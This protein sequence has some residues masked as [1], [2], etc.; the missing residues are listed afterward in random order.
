MHLGKSEF[1]HLWSLW[2]HWD[3]QVA[4]CESAEVG[5]VT[6]LSGV[7]CDPGNCR[8]LSLYGTE[9]R[10]GMIGLGE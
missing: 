6:M 1:G 10:Q 8:G 7:R 5:G 2:L 3:I 9:A 4:C